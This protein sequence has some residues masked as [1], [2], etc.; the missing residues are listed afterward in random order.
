MMRSEQQIREVLDLLDRI[1]IA[2][3]GYAPREVPNGMEW[4]RWVLG[5]S[6]NDVKEVLREAEEKEEV[7]MK[8][9]VWAPHDKGA[10]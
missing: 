5:E 1:V 2:M 6:P 8:G 4:L 3:G 7:R 10:R 9:G